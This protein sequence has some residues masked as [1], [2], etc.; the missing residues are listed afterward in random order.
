MCE[1][2]NEGRYERINE[3]ASV[4]RI[5]ESLYSALLIHLCAQTHTSLEPPYTSNVPAY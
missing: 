5:N 1:Q 3:Q 2:P 4:E